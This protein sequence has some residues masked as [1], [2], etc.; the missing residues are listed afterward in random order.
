MCSSTRG[1]ATIPSL[2]TWPT[3]K[4]AT[5]RLLAICISRLV[6]S[7]TWLTLPGAEFKS[8]RNMV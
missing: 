2:V 1:P 5:P 3:M 7:L 8:S 4:M 6:D